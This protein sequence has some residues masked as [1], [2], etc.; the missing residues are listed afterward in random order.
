MADPQPSVTTPGGSD[1]FA[2]LSSLDFAAFPGD[3]DENLGLLDPHGN[4]PQASAY[5]NN[6]AGGFM[7]ALEDAM[8]NANASPATSPSSSMLFD[9]E[10]VTNG[11]STEGMPVLKQET[12]MSGLGNGGLSPNVVPHY[13]PSPTHGHKRVKS[14]PDAFQN[15]KFQQWLAAT[16]NGASLRPSVDIT[17]DEGMMPTTGLDGGEMLAPLP[18]SI[19]SINT[20]MV[21]T[22]TEFRE[23]PPT[24]ENPTIPEDSTTNTG[25]GDELYSSLLKDM[26]WTDFPENQAHD[27]LGAMPIRSQRIQDGVK[28]LHMKR[29]RPGHARHLSN[30][31]DLLHNMDQFRILAQQQQ[32][33][34]QYVSPPPSANNS[35]YQSPTKQ[36]QPLM[37]QPNPFDVQMNNGGARPRHVR[38]H[39][40]PTTGFRSRR[41]HMRSGGG[42]P[43]STGLSTDMSQLDLTFL[44]LPED[45]FQKKLE[46]QRQQQSFQQAMGASMLSQS[47]PQR[48][49]NKKL[50]DDSNRKAYKCGRCG[51]P[52]VGHVC[53]MPELRNNWTQADLEVTKGL[54]LMRL[55]CH[56]VAVKSKWVPQHEDNL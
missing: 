9:H 3:E 34:Q 30:P 14:N 48:G 25:F 17:M 38:N 32:Q 8:G 45:E 39:S 29:K 2:T 50:A 40:L 16:N 35:P 15:P 37:T 33:A 1:V 42:V 46:E 28:E 47:P 10:L 5:L 19:G 56:I 21:S 11:F 23:L 24:Q 4:A 51:Q 26:P 20:V 36:L 27:T 18:I 43:G 12:T 13:Y 31:V 53:T 7:A 52:K 54:K 44:S 55:N 22:P 41:G 6:G 49:M